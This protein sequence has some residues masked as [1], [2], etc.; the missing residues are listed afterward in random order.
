MRALPVWL[1]TIGV[2]GWPCVAEADPI[3]I[4]QDLRRVLTD[5][6]VFDPDATD[7]LRQDSAGDALSTSS[8]VV[9]GQT[10]ASAFAT[11]TS[12]VTRQGIFGSGQLDASATV[13]SSPPEDFQHSASALG[14][15][16]F[17]MLIELDTP[18]TF[19]FAASFVGSTFAGAP[20]FQALAVLSRPGKD[21][22]RFPAMSPGSII[23]TGVIPA[24]VSLFRIQEDVQVN[25]ETQGQRSTGRGSFAFRFELTDVAQTPE[26]ASL[27]LLGS[28]LIGLA[29]ARRRI[30]VGC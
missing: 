25:A 14:V 22:F 19:E 10:R 27:I 21:V 13:P 23:A 18:Q 6:I 8:N 26:P 30:H 1:L 4:V 7:V 2:V 12:S 11:L 20:V 16:E 28:G 9:R 17:N 5:A 3:R 24:G 15:S 29:G